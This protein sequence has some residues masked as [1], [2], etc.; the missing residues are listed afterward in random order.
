MKK[1]HLILLSLLSGLLLFASWPPKGFPFLIFFAF[2]PLFFVSDFL[3]RKPSKMPF[4]SGVGYS[5]I[6]FFVWNVSTTWWIWNST[7]EGAIATFVLNSFFMSLVY[8]AWQRLC[9]LRLPVWCK[10]VAFI[11]FWCSWEYLHLNWDLTWPWLNLGNVFA[12]V[13]EYIQWYEYTGTFGGTIWIL[14]SNFLF[15]NLLKNIRETNSQRVL[16]AVVSILWIVLPAGLSLVRY[17][18]YTLPELTEEESVEAIVIQ[19]NMDVWEEEYSWTNEEHTQRLIAIAKPLLTP[20]TRIM[21]CSES[22]IPH[23]I[24]AKQLQMKDFPPFNA[25]YS[26][27]LLLDTLLQQY[28]GL[29]IITG[30]STVDIFNYKATETCRDMGDHIYMDF[31]NTSACY[32][33]HGLRSLYYKSKLVPGVEKMP[34]PKIF[35]FLEKLA[36]DLGGI[37]GSLG[38]DTAQ[39]VFHLEQMKSPIGVPI[40]YESAYGEH[41]GEFVRNGAEIMAVIT[42][43]SWWGDTPGHQQ[44]Y[45]FSKM[46]AV[47]T[48]HPILRAANS[49]ISAFIDERG[50]AHQVTQYDTQTAF[51]VNACPSKKLTFYTKK[52]DYLARIALSLTIAILLLDVI[53][54]LRS[55]VQSLRHPLNSANK[56]EQN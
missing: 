55:R 19:Q 20:R 38:E 31:H 35:G 51:K 41:F 53:M 16:W 2:I 9:T 28:P 30:L 54:R 34:Y 29:N 3:V 18:T 17:H 4:W 14:L 22:A 42:N 15:F 44:H 39:R 21:L 7:P 43:D 36:I 25:S 56:E 23:T 52:G 13:P 10:I 40:C 45:L 8:G 46:R 26:G 37:S 32:N 50:D 12:D 47:E 11:S 1:I 6:A 27:F 33:R 5:Y 49:G 48:R 24:F